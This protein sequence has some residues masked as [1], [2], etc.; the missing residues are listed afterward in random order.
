MIEN[1]L[2]KIA[3]GIFKKQ[4]LFLRQQGTR[5][6][7]EEIYL[8]LDPAKVESAAEDYFA[9]WAVLL[10]AIRNIFILLPI[11][12]TWLS[13]GLAAIAYTQIYRVYPDQSFL[14]LWAD[15]FPGIHWPVPDFPTVAALDVGLLTFLLLLTTSIQ[16]I[17][18]SAQ[19]KAARLRSELDVEILNMV[20]SSQ[21]HSLGAGPGNKKPAWAGEVQDAM[22]HLTHAVSSVE[23]LVRD[24][25]YALK[26]LVDTSQKTLED[27][28]Q[29]SQTK[30]EGSVREFSLALNNQRVAVDEFIAGTVDVRR[31]VDKLEHIYVEGESIYK[32]LNQT[33]P[34]IEASFRI[35]AARQDK[36]TSALESISGNNDRATRAVTEIAQQFTQ[37]DL[38][39]STA[40]AA[41]QMQQVAKTMENIA[42]DMKNTVKQQA[43]LQQQLNQQV[44]HKPT[45]AI[46]KKKK[47]WWRFW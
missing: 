11:L 13:L 46:G 42:E 33:M 4:L 26:L 14:K 32:G 7:P 9:R 47:K 2:A 15:G 27:L 16:F 8:L 23:A 18:W 25:H 5:I 28:V 40:R 31:A 17:E 34:Q 38:V 30:L 6:A 29:A 12:V 36:A 22:N 19:R 21:I 45:Q 10:E 1:D 24:S 43:N 3:G 39:G 37:T 44:S 20:I 41:G 35:M